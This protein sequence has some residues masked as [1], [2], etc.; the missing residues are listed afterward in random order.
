MHPVTKETAFH[1]LSFNVEIPN[2]LLHP[3]VGKITSTPA[4]HPLSLST[5]PSSN[6]SF[7]VSFGY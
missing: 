2:V 4:L 3:K 1:S 7:K 6:P 5:L